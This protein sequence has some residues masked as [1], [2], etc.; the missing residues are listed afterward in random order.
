MADVLK[1]VEVHVMV[2][3]RVVKCKAPAKLGK[4]QQIGFGK[5]PLRFKQTFQY[6]SLHTGR[7]KCCSGSV[8]IE[9]T[10]F[11]AFWRPG[12]A[13]PAPRAERKPSP[14]HSLLLF[15][16]QEVGERVF[17]SGFPVTPAC[18]GC[19]SAFRLTLTIWIFDPEPVPVNADGITLLSVLR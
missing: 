8:L 6:L 11:K 1:Q 13:R 19:V 3:L 15:P 18:Q 10:D 16:S 5:C 12:F 4:K 2:Y 17:P 9:K 14:G 7:V